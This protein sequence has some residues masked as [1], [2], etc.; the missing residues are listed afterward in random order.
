M[1]PYASGDAYVFVLSFGLFPTFRGWSGGVYALYASFPYRGFGKK[2][3]NPIYGC[4]QCIQEKGIIFFPLFIRVSGLFP[5]FF[6]M[7]PRMHTDAYTHTK[8]AGK[9]YNIVKVGGE[10][11]QYCKVRPPGCGRPAGTS[12][13]LFFQFETRSDAISIGSP[14]WRSRSAWTDARTGSAIRRPAIRS[15]SPGLPGNPGRPATTPVP[16]AEH[17]RKYSSNTYATSKHP[18]QGN[19]SP[20]SRTGVPCPNRAEKTANP[21]LKSRACAAKTGQGFS[22]PGR[23]R[24][25]CAPGRVRRRRPSSTR[26]PV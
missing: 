8:R 21:V 18:S 24:E 13:C 14:P 3:R 1:H 11:L 12:G 25:A 26:R 4:I 6:C 9:L 19:S 15:V 5:G 2:E 16:A 17:H 23:V 20:P 10:A 7:H 22:C